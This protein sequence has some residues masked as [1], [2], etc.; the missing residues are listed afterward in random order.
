MSQDTQELQEQVIVLC[1]ALRWYLDYQA[2]G[3][4]VTLDEYLSHARNALAQV[5]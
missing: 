2:S 1:D 3:E 5:D 4:I